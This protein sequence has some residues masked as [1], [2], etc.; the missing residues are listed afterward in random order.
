MQEAVPT[1][2]GTM[3]AIL[4]LEDQEVDQIC[5]RVRNDG[6]I[7][8]AAAYN[9]PGQ[10]VVA[11]EVDAVKRAGQLA[12]EQSA[13]VIPLK[14][15]APFHCSMLKPAADRLLEHLNKIQFRDP[16]IPYFANVDANMVTS[17]SDIVPKLTDQV[18]KPVRWTQSLRNM[19]MTRTQRFIEAGPGK[20]CVGHLRKVERRKTD[21]AAVFAFTDKE[22][23]LKEV[24]SLFG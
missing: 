11:G 20:V 6:V 23:E 8:E 19:F 7:V 9:C 3:Y 18:C 12:K 5:A 24:L 16:K 4:G 21:R 10:V 13:R 1:G 17:A 22:P 15:S 14:V 2:E